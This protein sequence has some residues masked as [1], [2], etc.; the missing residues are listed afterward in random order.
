L[1]AA[2]VGKV[3]KRTLAPVLETQE[4]I[5]ARFDAMD[6]EADDVED[7]EAADDE[8]A[9]AKCGKTHMGACKMKA[10]KKKPADDDDDEDDEDDDEDD[11]DIDSEIDKGDLDDMGPEEDEDDDEPGS[12]NKEAKNKGRKT[13][14]ESKTGKNV[15]SSRL[16]ASLARE[17]AARRENRALQMQVEELSASVKAIKKQV[18]AAAVDQGRRSATLLPAEIAGLLR[19]GGIDYKELQASGQK[20]EVDEVDAL[21][22]AVGGLPNDK[23]IQ[24]KTELAK[25]GIMVEGRV[26]R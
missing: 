25:R 23:R 7:V 24:L 15:S 20:L 2:A 26:Q 22:A 13:T 6:I 19:K 4:R 1:V 21:L 5:L 11:E 12:L 3:V 17:R 18:K 10:A 16:E 8:E 9:C 14:T